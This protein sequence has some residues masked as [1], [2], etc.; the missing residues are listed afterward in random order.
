MIVKNLSGI[1]DMQGA[2]GLAKYSRQGLVEKDPS[3]TPRLRIHD[4]GRDHAG[5]PVDTARGKSSHCV[6]VRNLT[7]HARE[8]TCGGRGK[9][10]A[11][12]LG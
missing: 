9:H 6:E 2:L 3:K 1:V 10:I 7:S 8:T 11:V 4:L 5:A 12:G